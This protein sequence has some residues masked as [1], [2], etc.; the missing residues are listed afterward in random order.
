M[1]TNEPIE[2][3]LQIENIYAGYGPLQVLRGFTLNL[4][5]G[6]CVALIGP[7]GAGKT[8]LLEAIVGGI[9]P[10]S[11]NLR[12]PDQQ[13]DKV[14]ALL[15]VAQVPDLP[16]F[17]SLVE[18]VVLGLRGWRQDLDDP[19]AAA[20][21]LLRKWGL[22]DRLDRPT[23]LASPGEIRR[24]LFALVEGVRPRVL[25]LDEALSALDPAILVQA[26]GLIKELSEEGCSTLIVTHDMGLAERIP[27][28]VALL[29]EGVLSD[30]WKREEIT[31]AR[32]EG[33]SLLDLYLR[34]TSN[35][36]VLD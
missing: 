5:P 6:E 3:G 28:R 13:D 24:A 27:D 16:P 7:N 26:E 19:T 11:G 23:R 14:P 4:A 36:E 10:S 15:R 18:L 35:S 34:Q 30:S 22:S 33:V 31:K 25:L 17:L 2:P 32:S 8:T 21:T 29:H 20:T 9:H 12:I 1:T